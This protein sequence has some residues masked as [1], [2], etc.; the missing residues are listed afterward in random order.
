[1][2]TITYLYNYNYSYKYIITINYINIIILHNTQ[3]HITQYNIL[4]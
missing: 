1:M 3:M 4:Y 2:I